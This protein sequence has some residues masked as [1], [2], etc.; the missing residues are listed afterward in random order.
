MPLSQDNKERLISIASYLFSKFPTGITRHAISGIVIAGFGAN[1]IFPAL[2]SYQLEGIVYNT[3]KYRETS[4]QNI[5]YQSGASI[6][7]FAQ[8]EM[9]AIFMEG[10]DQSYIELEKSYLTRIFQDYATAV[11][12]NAKLDSEASKVELQ[13]KLNKVGNGILTDLQKKLSQYR[14]EKFVQPVIRVVSMLPKDELAA[15]AESLV[16]LTSFKQKVTLESE[17]VGGP[18]DVAV[19][20]KGDGFIWIKR[21]HYFRP[22]LNQ[23]FFT[24]YYEDCKNG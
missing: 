24:N 23:H 18:I 11:V 22:E 12:E 20:S 13:N 8:S 4:R 1:E 10:A 6:I 19:I 14:N 17:T 7:P 5:D 2:I 3:L 16:N 9:V 15:M 21:K